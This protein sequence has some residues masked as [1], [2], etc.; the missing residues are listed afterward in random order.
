[1]TVRFNGVGT[2]TNASDPTAHYRLALVYRKL[3]R[4]QDADREL[5]IFSQK[6][7]APK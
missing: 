5:A 2:V 3:G 4:N 6:Q 7:A 1:M